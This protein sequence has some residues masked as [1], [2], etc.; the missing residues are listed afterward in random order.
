MQHILFSV[1]A[2]SFISA[3]VPERTV[4]S[5][6]GNWESQRVTE[7]E[8]P[9]TNGEWTDCR[10]PGYLNGTNY[11]RA[12]FRTTFQVPASMRNQRVQLRFGGVKYNSRV[13][14]NGR[15]V[16][17]CFGGYE[18]FAIDVTDAVKWDAPNELVVGCHDW[19]GVFTAGRVDLSS[20]K[21]WDALRGAPS[22]KVLSP[23]GGLYGLFGIW[24]D[25]TL[26]SHPA[27]HVRDVF[28]KPSV[29]N[30]ELVVSFEVA[31]DSAQDANSVLQAIV[32]DD[33]RSIFD[34]GAVDVAV[35]AGKVTTV[36]LRKPWVDP[37]LW[38][39]I[40][41]HLLSLKS[42]LESGDELRTRFGFR[43]FWVEGDKFFLN[44]VRVNLL[45][46]SWWPP[47]DYMDRAAIRDTWLKVK[48]MG[49]VAFRTHTQPWPA[50]HYDVAD[51]LGIL[52]VIEGA[53]W[54]DDDTYRIF[55]PQFWD[56]YAAHLTAMVAQ[57]KNRPSVVMWSLENEFFGGR[58]NDRSPAKADLVRMGRLVKSL[59]PTRPIFFESDGDPDGVA[60]CIGVHYP[61]EY[62]DF[63]CWPNETNWLSKPAPLSQMFLNGAASFE[64]KRDK[65][66]YLGEFL[67][68][69]SSDP[70]WHTV[71]YGDE[72][73][74]DYARY[75]NLA[76]AESWKM[77]II[78]YRNWE[79]GALSPWTVIEGGPLDETNPLY[80]AHQYAYQAV[81]AYPLEY[82]HRFFG[83]Q[84]ITRRLAVFN[85]ILESSNLTLTSQIVK[86]GEMLQSETRQIALDPGQRQHLDLTIPLPQ[87]AAEE[88][89]SWVWWLERDGRR[90]F[91]DQREWTVAAAVKLRQP[92]ARTGLYDPVGTT[93][94][95]LE[96]V[97][98]T[99]EPVT[100][101]EYLPTQ[102]DV[103]VIGE[104][105]FESADGDVT[106]VGGTTPTR[107][108]LDE[109]TDRGGRI[110]VLRQDR[111]PEGLFAASLTKMHATMTFP[112][113][114]HHPILK[115]LDADDFRYW[116]GDHVVT[117]A[118]L[119]RPAAG[120]LPLVVAGSAAGLDAC[121]LLLQETE[122]GCTV[123]C[124]FLLAEK[125]AVEP[126]AAR[127][128]ENLLE[129]LA[130]YHAPSRRT[131]VIGTLEFKQMLR[132]LGLRFDE[133][134]ALS[135]T[136]DWSRYRIV[137]CN[138]EPSNL[139]PLRDYVRQ[140]G[141][142]WFHRLAAERVGPV[143]ES[144]GIPLEASAYS[145]PVSRAE[146][147]N[148]WF[149]AI[150]REDLYWLGTHEG[151]AWDETPRADHMADATY[152]KRLVGSD[153][154]RYEIEDGELEGDIVVK[155]KPGVVFA[156]VGQA[157]HAVQFPQTGDYLIGVQ[158]RG[159]PAKGVF[160]LVRVTI[161]GQVAGTIG[162]DD[163]WRTTTVSVRVEAGSHEVG[164]A[165]INDGSDP[166][167]EDRNLYADY[168]VVAPDLH[169]AELEFL[170]TPA[171][172]ATGRCGKGTVVF[173]QL[174]WDNE[175]QNAR[176]ASR[177]AGTLLTALGGDFRVHGGTT[178]EAET[179]TPQPGIPFFS[180]SG[181]CASLA[182]TGYIATP[183]RVAKSG[184]FTME[185]LA[186][187][188]IAA[189]EYP[190]V[191]AE[192]NG[193]A[194]AT[195][196]LTSGEWRSY[197]ADVELPAGDHELRLQFT[198]DLNVN[199]QDRNLKIDKV[200]F[201]DE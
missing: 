98:V 43:E 27:L 9:P 15:H 129:W 197:V 64:W 125:I 75:R 95:A 180:N 12:W 105:C 67:W 4:V 86:S 10:V 40:A 127:I 42:R 83:G 101:L 6:N 183:L 198:N 19:T 126:A 87:V 143:A 69:P 106:I 151:I 108:A 173:D 63:T 50:A 123:F 122:G 8:E 144:F 3:D 193:R 120:S 97:G 25:V 84:T 153:F 139:E 171:A 186:A 1:V 102:L 191:A 78:G 109:F 174:G 22:D 188:T 74:R 145:G 66:L 150:L 34:L 147:E 90:V 53:V 167:R 113:A 68:I 56:N 168:V 135:S 142:V 58:L 155:Q 159:T 23:I 45:A 201:Y 99:L 24:D 29:R 16:G 94:L 37:P 131:A 60:D 70:S 166:P 169:A 146:G 114:V 71:F 30:R 148:A 2:L 175:Q 13:Y 172:L 72:A 161:D 117:G 85:D 35:P 124:Q 156:T 194:L 14:V 118:L 103:L 137:V 7:L 89:L 141:T 79:V 163:R 134:D 158:A 59:D 196:R 195:I 107:Q 32:E 80:M 31:N 192:L 116:R 54:N 128:L 46:T 200:T 181:T 18:A 28:I 184:R 48:Q 73:Y 110:L 47:H 20:N 140:G 121:P 182:C 81:A 41:P 112:Q 176:K 100:N 61:H 77:Q 51:E 88:R 157:R 190:I 199:G 138:Q 115:G 179:M 76:K 154:K 52:M 136:T 92:A 33:G 165:F 178:L 39:H 189:G 26:E 82:D 104:A 187:G 21:N 177:F 93:K 38:S 62:P 164:I 162:T 36:T 152:S 65:P 170:S 17:G 111:Y 96:S 119:S 55:D 185:L 5:L 11:E 91:E 49:C 44:G 130:N 160:P 132:N 57:H 133:G 149:D